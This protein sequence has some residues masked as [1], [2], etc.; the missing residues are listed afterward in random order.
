[1]GLASGTAE[2]AGIDDSTKVAEL[3]EFHCEESNQISDLR[4]LSRIGPPVPV[5]GNL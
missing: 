4:Y 5:I 2:A 3:V 1:M